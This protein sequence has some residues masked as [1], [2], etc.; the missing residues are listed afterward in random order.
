MKAIAYL[1]VS[2]REQGRSGL[3]LEA[4]RSYIEAFA[5]REGFDVCAWFTEVESG[6]TVSDTLAERPQ[7]A[8]AMRAAE[9]AGAKV[10][11]SKLDRLSRDVHFI[12]GLMR[13]K[14]PF[15]VCELG[16][17]VDNFQL[18]IYA[19]FAEKE[20]ALIS[21][22]TRAALGA[23]KAR[24]VKLGSGN[25]SAGARATAAVT[26]AHMER[27]AAFIATL[28]PLIAGDKVA[29]ALNAAGMLNCHGRPWSA[30][31]AQR[32]IRM[33]QCI[34]SNKKCTS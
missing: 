31:S 27:V 15:V 22:R 9:L 7:L 30:R 24:G 5:S 29:D 13:D 14:V 3:G 34:L 8:A 19:A 16:L 12:S 21:E 28:D 6:K 23:L 11:V 26:S 2:S 18:H 20:R 25:P 10:M 33:S 4:Q 17:R 1:R 32:A